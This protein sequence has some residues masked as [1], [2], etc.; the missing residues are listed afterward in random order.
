MKTEFIAS[1]CLDKPDHNQAKRDQ[2][3]NLQNKQFC[4]YRGFSVWDFAGCNKK[5]QSSV[6]PQHEEESIVGYQMIYWAGAPNDQW[7]VQCESDNDG[8]CSRKIVLNCRGQ[9]SV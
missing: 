5:Y 8:A 1:S 9:R 4:C 7:T 3:S 2:H 6:E